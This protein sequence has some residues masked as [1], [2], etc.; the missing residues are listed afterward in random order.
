MRVFVAGASGAV[1]SAVVGE[2]VRRGHEVTGLTRTPSKR[3]LLERLGATAAVA[4]ALDASGVASAVRAAAPEGVVSL[5]TSLPRNGPT[6]IGHLEPTN[7]L[8]EE[9][10]RNVLAAAIAAGARRFVGE[11]IVF[12]YG[13]GDLTPG[14]V[15]EGQP[16]GEESHR[17]LR[18]AID[19]IVSCERQVQDATSQGRIEGLCLRFG[20]YQGAGAPSSR[21]MFRMARRRMLPV[22]G[23]GRALHPWI[24]LTDAARAVADALERA[25]PASVY[26]VVDDEPVEFR[27]YAGEMARLAGAGPPLHVPYSLARVAAPYGAMFLSRPRLPV[28]NERLKR[29]LGWRPR[30]PT[31][32]EAL[33]PLAESDSW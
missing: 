9:G 16:P 2:L 24:E 27:D 22:I 21:Y 20:L 11:S 5:L 13:Y 14:P 33:A 30:F 12:V 17:G 32:R 29:E 25:E 18:R 3:P 10:T 4:D 31:Y 26:N 23:G 7:R 15:T 19:A 6:R 1:G 28:S 8:R